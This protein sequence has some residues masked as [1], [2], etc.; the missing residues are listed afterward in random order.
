MWI[1]PNTLE[2]FTHHYQ[3]RNAFPHTLL[4]A[5][6][7]EAD[8]ELIG[9]KPLTVLPV[10]EHNP[11]THIAMPDTPMLDGDAWVQGWVVQEVPEEDIPGRIEE[12]KQRLLQEATDMRWEVMNGGMTLPGGI[13]VG[14]T[15][16]DQ[17]RIT[18]V[19]ANA[20]LAGLTD[21]D[22]V[23][24][25]AA[26]GWARI[27]I[28]QVKTIAGAIGQFVQACYS[29]ERAHHEAIDLLTTAAEVQAYDVTA[30]WPEN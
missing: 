9:V 17:N 25:K 22:E 23:D 14:T 19:V 12:T 18:S 24:F 27:T 7:S 13:V 2:T 16:D 26:S 4:P 20:E 6:I 3:I 1:N 5:N 15:I 29:A 8:L 21:E 10:P 30:G 11:V 28:G